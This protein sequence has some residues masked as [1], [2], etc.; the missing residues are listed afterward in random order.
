MADEEKPADLL[1]EN[2][3]HE[4]INELEATSMNIVDTEVYKADSNDSMMYTSKDFAGSTF[5]S[6][7]TI[8]DRFKD[9][10]TL[11]DSSGD[12]LDEE[13]LAGVQ[14]SGNIN[15]SQMET[16]LGLINSKLNSHASSLSGSITELP[17]QRIQTQAPQL[18]P[19]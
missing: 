12:E 19:I 2:D 13:Q 8:L 17:P 14:P 7:N 15:N 3:E 5:G 18:S 16:S 9:D 11:L 1:E 6:N 4:E 10:E